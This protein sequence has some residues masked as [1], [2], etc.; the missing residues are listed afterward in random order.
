MKNDKK[1]YFTLLGGLTVTNLGYSAVYVADPSID[2]YKQK[3]DQT[4][5]DMYQNPNSA[6]GKQAQSVAGEIFNRVPTG[7][8]FIEG[9]YLERIRQSNLAGGSVPEGTRV[10][11]RVFGQNYILEATA[12]GIKMLDTRTGKVVKSVETVER[13]EMKGEPKDIGRYY[14]CGKSTCENSSW[15]QVAH[16]LGFKGIFIPASGTLNNYRLD[17]LCKRT[18]YEHGHYYGDWNCNIDKVEDVKTTYINLAKVFLNGG[19]NVDIELD[20]KTGQIAVS[21]LRLQEGWALEPDYRKGVFKIV[22]KVKGSIAPLTFEDTNLTWDINNLNS[23]IEN[24]IALENAD[25]Q[26]MGLFFGVLGANLQDDEDSSGSG[27]YGG[28]YDSYGSYYYYNPYQYMG[29]GVMYD[30]EHGVY[31]T[32][33]G[34]FES[35]DEYLKAKQQVQQNI[36]V[37]QTIFGGSE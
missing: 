6:L 1:L 15:T 32:S 27:S 34:D 14:R 2:H 10:S 12:N 16:F 20:G 17:I 36:Q 33:L 26:N 23:L 11:I 13:T 30:R 21:G 4:F 9:S 31:H 29:D 8:H 19:I 24:E 35:Y 37:F 7:N 25:A 28:Y 5:Y 3:T 22:K 18:V